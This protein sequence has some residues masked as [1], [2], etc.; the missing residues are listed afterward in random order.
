MEKSPP[1]ARNDLIE[2][3]DLAALVC[4]DEASLQTTVFE[5][6]KQLGFG[7]HTALFGEEVALKLRTRVYDIV[8]VSERFANGDLATNSALA[9]LSNLTLAV[10]REIF[11]VLIGPGMNTRSDMQAFL[12][13]VDLV[14]RQDD[15]FQLKTIAGRGI[16]RQEEIYTTFNSVL[17]AVR[18]G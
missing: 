7:I 8:V 11:A 17:K 13:S 16:V 2:E 4:V 1:Q 12:Y 14:V 5:Q 18:A 9:E 3:G 15:A 10:R 6:L